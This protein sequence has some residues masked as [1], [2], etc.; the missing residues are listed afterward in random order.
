MDWET[1][2]YINPEP[3]EKLRIADGGPFL[4]HDLSTVEGALTAPSLLRH[5]QAVFRVSKITHQGVRTTCTRRL[6]KLSK[7]VPYQVQQRSVSTNKPS[8]QRNHKH[9]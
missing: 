3:L 1:T 2:P 7:Y 8:T 6:Y 5:Y 4:P 9:L